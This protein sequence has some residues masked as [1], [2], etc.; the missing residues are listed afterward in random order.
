MQ[1]YYHLSGA[2][3]ASDQPN[4]E[5]R[6][7]LLMVGDEAFALTFHTDHADAETLAIFQKMLDS[8]EVYK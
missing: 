5:E 7:V 8:F 1:T 6:V 4:D 3:Q 2:F